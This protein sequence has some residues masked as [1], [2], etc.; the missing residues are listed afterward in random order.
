VIEESDK[1]SDFLLSNSWKLEPLK[2]SGQK[3]HTGVALLGY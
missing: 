2:K 1:P 3:A